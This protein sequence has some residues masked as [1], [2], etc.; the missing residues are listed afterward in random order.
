MQITK[1]Q[2]GRL[3]TLYAQLAAR[4]IGL[5]SSREERV[6]WAS[7]RL[8]KPVASFKDLTSSDAGFLIDSIQGQ[9]GVKVPAR[10]LDRHQ[11]RRYGLDGRRDGKEFEAQPEMAPGWM[12]CAIDDYYQRL[13]WDR[14]RF[15]AFLSSKASPLKKKAS[16]RIVTLADANKVRFALK[17]M[18][19][20]A[21]L[22]ED[23][24]TK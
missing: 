20:A 3:Q 16:P 11:A 10:R 2:L 24:G 13:G 1:A 14:A 6:A 21:G 7:E 5:G 15:D 12:L 17:R 22:W 18:R 8:H 9:L 4:T 19:V 23:R